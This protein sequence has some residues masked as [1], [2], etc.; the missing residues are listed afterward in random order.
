MATPPAGRGEG[1]RCAA[2]LR[3]SLMIRRGRRPTF[4]FSIRRL[5]PATGPTVEREGRTGMVV[6]ITHRHRYDH[7]VRELAGMGRPGTRSPSSAVLVRCAS[8]IGHLTRAFAVGVGGGRFRLVDGISTWGPRPSAGHWPR[9]RPVGIPLSA[10]AGAAR[11]GGAYRHG[12][13]AGS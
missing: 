13:L 8:K 2:L 3:Q 12:Q 10:E 1:P 6:R 4:C 5:A 9:A 7:F 11:P